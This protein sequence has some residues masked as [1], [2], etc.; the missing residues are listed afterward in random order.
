MHIIGVSGHLGT[1]QSLLPMIKNIVTWN[2]NVYSAHIQTYSID[3]Q[4]YTLRIKNNRERI[5]WSMESLKLGEREMFK[6]EKGQGKEVKTMKDDIW[7][8]NPVSIHLIQA[9]CVGYVKCL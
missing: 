7:E 2:I 3:T 1:S 6:L 9:Q 4:A 5:M 8:F